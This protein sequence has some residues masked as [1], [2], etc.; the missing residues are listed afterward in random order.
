M[1][2]TEPRQAAISSAEHCH[3]PLHLLRF[4]NVLSLFHR[5]CR[6]KAVCFVQRKS[7]GVDSV[8]VLKPQPSCFL[9]ESFSTSS[10]MTAAT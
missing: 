3:A 2:T 6:E 10:R 5:L 9:Q 7:A 8:I 4:A 1:H